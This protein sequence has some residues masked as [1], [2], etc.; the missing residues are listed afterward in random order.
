MTSEEVQTANDILPSNY[1]YN[2]ETNSIDSAHSGEGGYGSIDMLE[3][4]VLIDY[5]I[6][7]RVD[8]YAF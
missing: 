4:K 2:N 6:R 8:P 7:I 1:E 3:I 5:L